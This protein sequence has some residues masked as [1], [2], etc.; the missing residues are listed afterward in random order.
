MNFIEFNDVSFSYPPVEDDFDENGK[1]IIPS[2]ILEHF[3]ATFPS[4]FVSLIGPNG[5][6]KSTFMLLASGRL[7]P[8]TGSISLM[9]KNLANIPGETKN[10]FASVIYQNMEFETE[11]KVKTLLSQ[12]YT[13]GTLQGKAKAILDE[14]KD[15][16][17]EVIEVFELEAVLEHKLTG[18][19]KGELQR[20]LL[21]FSILYGSVS[22]FMDE[23]LFAMEYSQKEKALAYLKAFC[24]KTGTSVYIS[25]HELD[26]T[27]KFADNVLLF[28]PNHN[29]T[30]GSVDEVLDE[31]DLEKAYGVPLALLKKGEEYT[32]KNLQ[33]VA[34]S[35][36]EMNDAL[37]K[38]SKD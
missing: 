11:E 32:R 9:G 37:A 31:K 38:G 33:E 3:T 8:D 26:L 10:M 15:L 1:Q 23:P 19:S 20:V 5:S 14:S 25:M 36:K 28:Y 6:G 4:G 29:M 30:F 2:P 18:I 35:I 17:A 27:K 22:V 16:L 7:S 12:V 24:K 21:A 13:S 34:Q